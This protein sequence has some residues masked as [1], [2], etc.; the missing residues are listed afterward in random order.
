LTVRGNETGP[1]EIRLEPCGTITGRIV[2]KDGLPIPNGWMTP[3]GVL[4][5]GIDEDFITAGK[6]GRFERVVLPG[7]KYSFHV[8]LLPGGKAYPLKE[9][10]LEPG[11]TLDLGDVLGIS[12]RGS[13]PK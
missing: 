13:P 7:W 9:I 4:G 11:Q 6:D 3:I 5:G 12:I 2:S 1:L 10:M 8:S